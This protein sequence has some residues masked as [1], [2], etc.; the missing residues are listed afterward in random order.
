VALYRGYEY[1]NSVR[2]R[3][4]LSLLSSSD[5]NQFRQA[6]SNER[7]IELAF[8]NYRWFDLKRTLNASELKNLLNEHGKKEREDPTTSQGGIPFFQEDYTFEE[9][10][11]L[12]PISAD[13]FGS[14]LQL[15]KTPVINLI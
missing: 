15:H 1:L 7:R 11:V 6:V 8:E 10:Q 9:Y 2:V 14:I 12:F 13:K 4:T 5:K 3:A